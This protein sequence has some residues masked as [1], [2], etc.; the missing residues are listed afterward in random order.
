M[1]NNSLKVKAGALGITALT[2]AAVLGGTAWARVEP[3]PDR[4]A[5]DKFS[6]ANA[7]EYA[8]TRAKALN[9]DW[10][11]SEIVL[12][13]VRKEPRTIDFDRVGASAGDVMIFDDTLWNSEGTAVVGRFL[14]RCVQLTDAMHLCDASLTFAH[15]TISLSAVTQ[16]GGD[17][18]STV[19]GGTGEH[20]GASGQALITPTGTAGI[21]QIRVDLA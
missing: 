20:A 2:I 21:F 13:D 1:T 16:L 3:V 7:C 14:G 9:A 5:C 19:T 12:R 10:S 15:G 18:V 11:G 17:S 6:S 8:A 4:P